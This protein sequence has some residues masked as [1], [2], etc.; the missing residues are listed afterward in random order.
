MYLAQA[1]GPAR[2]NN[3]HALRL[4]AAAAVIVSHAWPLAHGPGT[5]EPLEAL[6]GHALGGWAVVLFFFLSGL[7]IAQSAATRSAAAFWIAR[8]R[9][10]LPGLAVALVVTLLLAAASGAQITPQTAADY[11]LRGLTLVSLEHRIAGAYAGNPY[12]LAVNGPLWSLF[13]EVAAYA[14]CFAAIR[15]GLVQR[16]PLALLILSL[17]LWAAATLWTLPARLETFAPLFLAF[18]AGVTV[19]RLRARWPLSLPLLAILLICAPLGWP[20]AVAALGQAA[21]IFGFRAPVIRLRHDLS[22]GAYIYGWPVAQYIL[23]QMPG[24]TAPQLAI[25]SLAATLPLALASWLL[26]ETPALRRMR[27]QPRTA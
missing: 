8:A 18:A 14:I 3:L 7:L 23:H 22:Y 27:T 10:I 20:F 26:V 1:F 2:P 21:L 6:T 25:L 16:A 5:A 24:M 17:I 19:W 4:A 11:I 12:A 15:T 9:R 13:H